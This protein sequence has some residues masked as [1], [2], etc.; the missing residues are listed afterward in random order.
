MVMR[1]FSENIINNRGEK[2]LTVS[3][4]GYYFSFITF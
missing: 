3:Y 1:G 4:N 2:P